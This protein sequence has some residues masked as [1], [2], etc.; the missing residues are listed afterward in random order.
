MHVCWKTLCECSRSSEPHRSCLVKCVDHEFRLVSVSSR[1]KRYWSLCHSFVTDTKLRQCFFIECFRKLQV[2]SSDKKKIVLTSFAS[3]NYCLDWSHSYHSKLIKAKTI[4]QS[5]T[6]RLLCWFDTPWF[7]II[8]LGLLLLCFCFRGL[9]LVPIW[10]NVRFVWHSE[11]NSWAWTRSHCGVSLSMWRRPSCP[12]H[13]VTWSLSF[14]NSAISR[15][16]SIK[17]K[18]YWSPSSLDSWRYC[19]LMQRA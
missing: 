17:L 12:L 9:S 14:V 5:S 19:C 11:M 7:G 18:H 16:C 4:K 15:D 10:L 1:F 13:R 2:I 3:W 6:T 8:L